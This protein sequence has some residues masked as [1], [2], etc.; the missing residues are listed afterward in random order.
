MV[1]INKQENNSWKI[2]KKT[3]VGISKILHEQ[4]SDLNKFQNVFTIPSV[5]IVKFP[6]QPILT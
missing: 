2:Y 6:L 4:Q 5:K 1:P 3:H